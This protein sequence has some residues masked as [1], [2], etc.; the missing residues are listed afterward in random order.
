MGIVYDAMDTKLDRRVAVKQLRRELAA[1]GDLE[2]FLREAKLAAKLRHPNIVA[3]LSVV[4][5]SGEAFIVFE[6]VDGASLDKRL[7]GGG[8]I[9]LKEARPILADVCGALGC[10]H[11]QRIIHRDL[12]PANI[13]IDISGR[14]RI[15]DFGIAHQAKTVSKQT[16]TAPWGT[17]DYMAP[18]QALG[19]VSPASDL[20]ALGIMTYEMLTGRLPFGGTAEDKLTKIFAPPS[21]L[22]LPSA[23]DAFFDQALEPDPARRFAS[24][25]AFLHG[26]ERLG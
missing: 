20:Y 12:K 11:G 26:F 14:A 7:E 18:E 19:R 9:D 6:F 10:A 4:E 23:A 13:L 8:K 21:K 1:P 25:E 24:A 3:V 16:A 15:M 2:R 17:P 5:Q 22:G